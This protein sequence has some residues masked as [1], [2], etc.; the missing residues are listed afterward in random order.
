MR[1]FKVVNKKNIKLNKPAK[2]I[3]NK[4]RSMG[5]FVIISVNNNITKLK[6]ACAR[7]Y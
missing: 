1:K 7:K 5:F 3:T 4:I 2:W 6:Y